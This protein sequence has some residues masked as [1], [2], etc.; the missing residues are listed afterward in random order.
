MKKLFKKKKLTVKDK[1]IVFD[2]IKASM[3]DIDISFGKVKNEKE[4]DLFIN[5]LK[6]EIEKAN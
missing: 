3:S 6:E 4:T 1:D 2:L 5:Q